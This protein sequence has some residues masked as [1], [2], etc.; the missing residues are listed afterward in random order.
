MISASDLLIEAASHM[1]ERGFATD[2]YESTS[3]SVCLEGAVRAVLVQHGLIEEIN[4]PYE[5][6][7][8]YVMLCAALRAISQVLPESVGPKSYKLSEISPTANLPHAFRVYSY[9]DT[10]CTGGVEAADIL[11]RAS[12]KAAE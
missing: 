9:N 11:R 7:E 10:T 5:S 8:A 1:E 6:D 3:G 2:T 12:K 4:G